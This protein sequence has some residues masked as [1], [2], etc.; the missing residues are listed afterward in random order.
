[1]KTLS[2]EALDE[3]VRRLA[4]EFQPE[5]IILFG[6]HAWGTPHE[7]SDIDLLVIVSNNTQKL[8]QRATRA[9]RCLQGLKIPK[10]ILVKTRDEVN[11]YKGVFASLENQILEKG[12][13]LYG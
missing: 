4:K 8:T 13:V 11:R 12:R 5:Q 3:M 6:S 7:D 1:M 10:D 9:Y 2:H